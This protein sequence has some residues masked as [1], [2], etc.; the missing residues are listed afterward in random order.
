MPHI[1]NA[2]SSVKGF[3][4]KVNLRYLAIRQEKPKVRK[5]E[6]AFSSSRIC[7][8]NFSVRKDEEHCGLSE[9]VVC[10]LSLIVNQWI[11]HLRF[12][13]QYRNEKKK[14]Q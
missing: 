7:W 10:A 11:Y 6:I 12:L 3:E 5:G 1:E 8:N 13:N 14:C 9:N 2:K 4:V